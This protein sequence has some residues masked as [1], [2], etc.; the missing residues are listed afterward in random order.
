MAVEEKPPRRQADEGVGDKMPAD[1]GL[2]RDFADRWQKA[3][4]SHDPAQ[5][6]AL[7]T[8]DVVWEDP[9]TERPER[10]R[11]AVTEYLHAV[12]LALP[13][14]RF[15]WPEGPYASFEGVKLALHWRVSGTMLGRMEPPGFAPTGRTFEI[16]GVDLLELR[17]G[18]V[19]AYSGFFDVRG[20][21]QQIG[22]LPAP[23]SRGERLAVRAQNLAARLRGRRSHRGS[24]GTVPGS[25][26]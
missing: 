20:I 13:D 22:A 16:E 23:G 8:E 1:E 3:W 19:C 2:A 17:D 15:I 12:W 9:L 11:E 10:G 25:R 24:V 14:L 21:A 5:V 18:L 26:Q 4:N 6:V 7:C